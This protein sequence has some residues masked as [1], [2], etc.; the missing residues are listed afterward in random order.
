MVVLHTEART[1]GI[2]WMVL[3]MIGYFALPPPPR[4]R[5]ADAYRIEHRRARPS[6]FRELAYGSALVPIFGTD[7]DAEAMRARGAARRA[8]T[9]PWTRSTCSR[10]RRQLS[11][12]AGLDER[13]DE[14]RS[15]LDAARLAGARAQG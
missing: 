15:V 4:A 1:V 3:G 6:D 10:S 12:D 11:L 5:P 8:T 9:R 14:A 13:G 7:V 2:A